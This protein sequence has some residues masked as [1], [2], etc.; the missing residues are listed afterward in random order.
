VFWGHYY[1]FFLTYCPLNNLQNNHYYV[2]RQLISELQHFPETSSS[3]VSMAGG[4]RGQVPN[5]EASRRNHNV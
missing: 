3:S 4:H 2:R 1:V 5:E